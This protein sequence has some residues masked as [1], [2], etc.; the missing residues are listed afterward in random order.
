MSGTPDAGASAGAPSHSARRTAESSSGSSTT[1]L[2]VTSSFRHVHW[3]GKSE[4]AQLPWNLHLEG[5]VLLLADCESCFPLLMGLISL[6]LV[7]T[8]ICIFDGK[9]P[10]REF[11][12]IVGVNFLHRKPGY[13]YKKGYLKPLFDRRKLFLAVLSL[14]DPEV[15]FREEV[16]TEF[17]GPII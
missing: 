16:L 7:V 9:Q 17:E 15:F 10:P 12:N 6:G 5:H 13:T 11:S 14:P 3:K 8:A 4:L 1:L 2:P